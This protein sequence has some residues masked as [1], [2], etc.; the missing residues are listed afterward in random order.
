MKV[1]ALGIGLL[2][3][4]SY[5]EQH[6][7]I[8]TRLPSKQIAI[9]TADRLTV[10]TEANQPIPGA[11]VLIGKKIDDPFTG[12]NL[13]TDASGQ[14]E[15]PVNFKAPLPVTIQAPGYI[16]VTYSK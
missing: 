13:T 7:S 4:V 11:N 9:K 6:S 16:T 2:S 5:A 1:L 10:V 8:K 15:I 3:L 14:V 12:N